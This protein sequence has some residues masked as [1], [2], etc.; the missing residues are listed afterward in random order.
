MGVDNVV[1][2]DLLKWFL[3]FFC[4]MLRLNLGTIESGI[5][6]SCLSE[7]FLENK[8][9]NEEALASIKMYV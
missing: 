4:V 6:K 7:A 8:I 5:R 1:P 9:P 2:T 3:V